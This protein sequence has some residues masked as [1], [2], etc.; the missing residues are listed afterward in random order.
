MKCDS[1]LCKTLLRAVLPLVYLTAE[2][3]TSVW[4]R[5]PKQVTGNL[6]STP[7]EHLSM[8]SCINPPEL[9]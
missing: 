8:L 5:V 9:C 4:C 1:C 2:H 3:C 6:R 7:I